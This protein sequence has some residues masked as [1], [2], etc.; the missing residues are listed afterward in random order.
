MGKGV[1][2]GYDFLIREGWMDGEQHGKNN[3]FFPI[4]SV[5][6]RNGDFFFGKTAEK[7]TL[8]EEVDVCKTGLERK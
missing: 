5:F 1:I 7:V 4:R 2:R 6:L 8:T 3:L